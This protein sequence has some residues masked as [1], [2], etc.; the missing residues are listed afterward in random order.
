[1]RCKTDL[2]LYKFKDL[3]VVLLWHFILS[4]RDVT[5]SETAMYNWVRF[6]LIV[7]KRILNLDFLLLF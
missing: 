7:Q 1:M 2:A 6:N 4:V 3:A 5:E